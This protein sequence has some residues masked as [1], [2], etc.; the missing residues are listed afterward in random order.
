MLRLQCRNQTRENVGRP[1]IPFCGTKFL[2]TIIDRQ[3]KKRYR[4]FCRLHIEKS[5]YLSAYRRHHLLF[6]SMTA[7]P[8]DLPV[9]ALHAEAST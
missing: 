6:S 7:L 9:E 2:P 4:K 1:K 5:S 8:F 3:W